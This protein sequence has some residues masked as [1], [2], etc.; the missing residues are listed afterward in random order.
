MKKIIVIAILTIGGICGFGCSQ[1]KKTYDRSDANEMFGKICNL[2]KEYTGKLTESPDSS[3]WA[4]TCAEFEDKLDK[5]NFSYPPDT[6]LLLTEGQNDTI[7]ALMLEYINARDERI[8]NILHP[9]IEIDSIS[10]F[11]SAYVAESVSDVSQVNA[12]RSHGN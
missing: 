2:T 4:A 5:I 12:S 11:D 10:D 9:I 1:E 7:H 6:D 3:T 8:H